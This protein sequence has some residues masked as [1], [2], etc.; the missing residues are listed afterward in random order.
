[1]RDMPEA[2][3]GIAVEGAAELV[4]Q[5]A[6][7][8]GVETV[9][10]HRLQLAVGVPMAVAQQQGKRIGHGKFLA[11]PEAAMLGVEGP[12]PFRGCQCPRV[13]AL[14]GAVPRWRDQGG[15]GIAVVGRGGQ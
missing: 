1:M 13:R 14:A 12:A 7:G 15:Q 9:H 5:A 6:G 3:D 10:D 4:A 8:H 11:S 2:I